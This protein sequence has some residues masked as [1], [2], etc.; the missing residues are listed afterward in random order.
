MLWSSKK[1]QV[2]TQSSTV[3]EYRALAAA[4][5]EVTWLQHLLQE[6]RISL[7]QTLTLWCDNLSARYLTAIPIFHARIKHIEL[8]FHFVGE[9]VASKDLNV[10]YINF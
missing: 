7:P 8:N 10:R 4:T 2:V 9:K 5:A 1:Q 3:A 6:L